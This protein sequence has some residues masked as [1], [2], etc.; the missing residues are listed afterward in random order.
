M[1]SERESLIEDAEMET[2]LA[3]LAYFAPDYS[4]TVEPFA[5]ASSTGLRP[6]RR[7]RIEAVS[8]RDQRGGG[9]VADVMRSELLSPK[10]GDAT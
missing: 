1:S 9:V 5:A 2:V 7:A 3:A 6:T 10:G 4:V 8:E